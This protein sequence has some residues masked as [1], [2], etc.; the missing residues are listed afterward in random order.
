MLRLEVNPGDTVRIGQ[1]VVMR[2][3]AR[4][5]RAARLSFEAPASVQI[6]LVSQREDAPDPLRGI[7]HAVSA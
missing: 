4:S 5:G 7:M 3:E 2:M 6:R 1:N